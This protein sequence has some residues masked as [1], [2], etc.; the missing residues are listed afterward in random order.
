MESTMQEGWLNKYW[1]I[2]ENFLEEVGLGMPPA[3]FWLSSAFIAHKY[4][5]Q[6]IQLTWICEFLTNPVLGNKNFTYF[7]CLCFLVC[8]FLP[9]LL[10][11]VFFILSMFEITSHFVL[12]DK[13]PGWLTSA[14]LLIISGLSFYLKTLFCPFPVSQ[15]SQPLTSP[16]S[17]FE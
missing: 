12:M 15:I 14:F 5:S 7:V 1:V 2:Q 6:V 4:K 10:S 9:F 8:L 13:T 3:V 11:E 17:F 16:Y